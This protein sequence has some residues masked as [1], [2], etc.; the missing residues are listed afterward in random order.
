M[1]WKMEGNKE[2]KKKIERE[3]SNKS[4]V[5]VRAIDGFGNTWFDSREKSF[6]LISIL[7]MTKYICS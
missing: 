4:D 2:K 3:R 7:V 6:F 5:R 1:P